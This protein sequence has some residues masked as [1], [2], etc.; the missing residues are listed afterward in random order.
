M[1]WK[2]AKR[3]KVMP[4][5]APTVELKASSAT[6]V[7][8]CARGTAPASCKP[9]TGQVTLSAKSSDVDGDSLLYTFSTTG[10]RITGDGANV[11]WDLSGAQTGTYTATVEVDDGCGCI[12]FSSTS[13]SVVECDDCQ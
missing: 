5:S 10:G 13:V 12:A 8:G 4:N 11:V 2:E 9:D 3:G 6:V 7:F 1:C